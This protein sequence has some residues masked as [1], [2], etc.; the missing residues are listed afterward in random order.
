MDEFS[1]ALLLE[2]AAIS[3]LHLPRP[4]RRKY[5][6]HMAMA[7]ARFEKTGFKSL[8]RRSLSQAVSIYRGYG[9][10]GGRGWNAIRSHCFRGLG[11]QAYNAGKAVE[12]VEFFLELPEKEEEGGNFG[13]REEEESWLEDFGLAWEVSWFAF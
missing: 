11:R 7:A 3:D 2:Q 8:S 13:E 1:S 6:F 5:A 9:E 12:A 4:S 10:G